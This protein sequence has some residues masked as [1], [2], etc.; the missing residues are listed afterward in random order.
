MAARG[1]DARPRGWPWRQLGLGVLTLLCG[2]NGLFEDNPLYTNSGGSGGTTQGDGDGD[3]DVGDGDGDETTQGDG[4]GDALPPPEGMVGDSHV[5]IDATEVSVAAYTEFLVAQVPAP[6]SPSRCADKLH[7][8]PNEWS[9]QISANKPVGGVDWCDAYAYCE[10]RGKRLCAGDA[11]DPFDDV[12][13]DNEW[14]RACA[15]T[16]L[17]GYPYGGDYDEQA[18]NGADKGFEEP[19]EVGALASCEGGFPGLFDMSGNVWEWTGVCAPDPDSG[20]DVCVRRGGSCF[21]GGSLLDCSASSRRAP[22]T[23]EIWV[24]FRCCADPGSL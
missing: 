13:L 16:S 5:W 7:Y 9:E 22:D 21:S 14:F 4:D 3:G 24:G 17:N 12:S 11:D 8:V 18:C 6:P 20:D 10:W 23:F 1:P 19:L 15:T 2:C